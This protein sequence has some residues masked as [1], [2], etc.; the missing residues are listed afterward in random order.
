MHVTAVWKPPLNWTIIYKAS[1][2]HIATQDIPLCQK[3]ESSFKSYWR[4]KQKQCALIQNQKI[5]SEI[6]MREMQYLW[7]GEEAGE[8]CW[9]SDT[10]HSDLQSEKSDYFK[11]MFSQELQ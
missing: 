10:G 9:L 5:H 6:S 2:Q 1:V 3:M 4:V 8:E 7:K 11:Q